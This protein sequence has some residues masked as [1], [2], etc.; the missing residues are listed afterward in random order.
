MNGFAFDHM[1]NQKFPA[2][3]LNR[4]KQA[5][6]MKF[7]KESEWC[8][9]LKTQCITSEKHT[10]T[11]T[12]GALIGFLS[13]SGLLNHLVFV[14]DEAGQFN[15]FSHALC[16]IHAERK[17]TDLIPDTDEQRESLENFLNLF[18]GFYDKLKLYKQNPTDGMRSV[19]K[20]EY[21]RIFNRSTSW[22][23]L[24]KVLKSFQN[25]GNQLLMVLNHP[26]TPLS[27]NISE[28]D[29]RDIVKK[30][31]ISAGTRSDLGRKCRDTF[32]SLNKTCSKSG[33][34]FLQYVEDRIS[35]ENQIPYL[36]EIISEKA[37]QFA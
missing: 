3:D 30:R 15:V 18:W 22:D 33:I 2:S 35:R 36:T 17:L 29:I 23:T 7:N 26:N 28:R 9:F 11:A 8:N 20:E 34:S 5:N 12:E 31:K 1:K 19:L 37:L 25:N 32:A 14:S 16:W 21:N 6:G 13:A 4:L 24:N 10:K 27:N